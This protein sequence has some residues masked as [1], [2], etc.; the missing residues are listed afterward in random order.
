MGA[1]W[2]IQGMMERIDQDPAKGGNSNPC[3]PY[4]FEIRG[5]HKTIGP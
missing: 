3:D 5:L 1:W 2:D 4:D